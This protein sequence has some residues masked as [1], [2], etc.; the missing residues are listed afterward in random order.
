MVL[1]T[2]RDLIVKLHDT[3][4]LSQS[5]R[6]ILKIAD[7]T[8][9]FVSSVV[10]GILRLK[11]SAST[12]DDNTTPSKVFNLMH[13]ET[14]VVKYMTEVVNNIGRPKTK[15]TQRTITDILLDE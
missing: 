2:V 1:N 6:M 12:Y 10:S 14:D 3:K 5:D 4:R 8:F 7:V 11:I 15:I 13:L 9:V